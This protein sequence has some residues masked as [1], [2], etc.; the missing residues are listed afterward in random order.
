LWHIE[1]NGFARG[2]RRGIANVSLRKFATEK[3]FPGINPV[4]RLKRASLKRKSIYE[5]SGRE[6]F[7][8]LTQISNASLMA[9]SRLPRGENIMLRILIGYC[10]PDD[11]V[12]YFG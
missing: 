9:M 10:Y 7:S 1:G 6:N 8:C 11:G 2:V 12:L 5:G 4:N 3:I